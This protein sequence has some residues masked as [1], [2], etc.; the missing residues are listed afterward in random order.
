MNNKRNFWIVEFKWNITSLPTLYMYI[1]SNICVYS[2]RQEVMLSLNMA[3]F[4][5]KTKKN[6]KTVMYLPDPVNVHKVYSAYNP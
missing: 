4:W 5:Q 2:F 1:I 6:Q 3:E